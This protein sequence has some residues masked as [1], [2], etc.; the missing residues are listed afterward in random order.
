ME[1]QPILLGADLNCY[2]MARAFYEAGA[3]KCLAIGK[4]RLGLTGYSRFVRFVPDSRMGTD[5]GRTEC[6]ADLDAGIGHKRGMLIGCTDEYAS[7]LIRNK[8]ELEPYFF[9]PVP[10]EK[11]LPFSD[12]EIFLNECRDLDIT[13]P[14]TVFMKGEERLPKVPF[15]PP[16]VLKPA[17]SEEYWRHP[18]PGICKAYFPNNEKEADNDRK[19]IRKAGYTGALLLQKRIPANDSDN[20]VLTVYCTRSGT[21]A[22]S[23]FGRV[24]MEEHTPRGTGNH[25]AILTGQPLPEIA[26]KLLAMLE[27]KKYTGFANFD[28][29]RDK[30]TGSFYALEINL[31]QGRSNHYLCASG[32]NPAKLLLADYV[33]K[34]DFPNM[35]I[36]EEKLWHSLPLSVVYSHLKDE[37][38]LEQCRQLEKAKKAVSPLWCKGD[39]LWN[40]MRFLFVCEH[41][42]RQRK[43]YR[44]SG[45]A[46]L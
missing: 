28:L 12:K 45:E 14:E 2:S 13:V 22:A 23:A 44:S 17:I 43:R 15:P 39:L 33:G 19:M 4:Y 10:D 29:I 37:D 16:Y 27:K 6:L 38:L 8:K 30:Y 32:L 18:F 20:Y 31:R 9:V 46:A 3:G 11:W 34:S 26:F 40:P 35:G 1:I 42:R 41:D 25:A 7:Y 36:R 5:E 21:V 24:L